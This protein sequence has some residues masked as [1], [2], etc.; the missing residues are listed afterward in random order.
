MTTTFALI[1]GAGDSGWCWHLVEAELRSRGHRTVAPDL[2]A[3]YVVD[4]AQS[5]GARTAPLV[6]ARRTVSRLILVAGMVPTPGEPP[7]Q[8]WTNT[9]FAEAVRE[10]AALGGGLT[11]N[12]HAYLLLPRRAG[13]VDPR[14]THAGRRPS[15]DG[16]LQP[17]LAARELAGRAHP[18]R[19]VHARASIP[20][21]VP[22]PGRA[23]PV[24]RHSRRAGQRA[25]RCTGPAS[26]AR[27]TAQPVTRHDP[28][29]RRKEMRD[30]RAD[31]SG[32]DSYPGPCEEGLGSSDEAVLH[33]AVV[34]VGHNF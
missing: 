4:V 3:D 31:V 34:D 9:G 24:P 15:I 11:G 13:G 7:D 25:L 12:H 2:P 8:V 16:R 32:I 29:A 22:P 30:A 23:G 18:I 19:L 28:P 10:Q 33:G 26:A 21:R 6:A 5:F 20:G 17:A 27:R 14:S 1:H